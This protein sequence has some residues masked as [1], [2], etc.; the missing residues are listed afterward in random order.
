MLC[1]VALSPG[2]VLASE[3]VPESPRSD[4]CPHSAHAGVSIILIFQKFSVLLLLRAAG[5]VAAPWKGLA[6]L[7]VA[8]PA[9]VFLCV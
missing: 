6:L 3:L 1:Q 9:P 7:R 4:M 5:Q 8:G 2:M